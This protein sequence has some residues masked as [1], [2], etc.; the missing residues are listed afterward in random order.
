MWNISGFT[1]REKTFIFKFYNN[2]LGINT[3]TSHFAANPTRGCFFCSKLTPAVATDETFLHLY[4]SCPVTKKWHDQFMSAYLPTLS[5]NDLA[6]A[7]NLWLLGI[8][9]DNF[10]LFLCSAILTFQFCIWECKLKKS[11]PSFHGLKMDFILLF[12]DTVKFNSGITKSGLL[13]NYDLCR[14]FLGDGRERQVHDE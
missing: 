4:F 8:A 7:K 6:L 3:R 11:V 14:F 2:I 5:L 10:N 12:R 9:G 1:N 13:L